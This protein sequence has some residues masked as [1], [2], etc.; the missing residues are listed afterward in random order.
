MKPKQYDEDLFA[1]STMTFGEHLE[2]LRICLWKAILGLAA[3]VIVG[4][5]F[6]GSVVNLIQ[7]PLTSALSKYYQKDA[8]AK[9]AARAGQSGDK[10][11]AD[12]KVDV[13]AKPR[14]MTAEEVCID[15]RELLAKLNAAYP[16]QFEDIQLPEKTDSGSEDQLIHVF[17]WRKWADDP[18]LHLKV[19]NVWEG[20]GIYVK[21]AFL[22]GLVL[23]SPWVFYQ[24]WNFVAAGLYPHEKK[25]VYFYLP[26]SMGLFIFGAC[27]A[28]LFVFEPVLN[29]LFEVNKWLGIDL[30]PR[31]SEWL[32]FALILPVGFG[33]GF[34]LP[35]VMYFLERVGI[36]SAGIFAKHW[37]I[38]VLLIW[39]LATMLTP[40][41]PFSQFFLGIPLTFL[42]FGGILLCKYLPKQKRMMSVEG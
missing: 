25:Y 23:S 31:I 18:R 27:V 38:A 36:V 10:S 16:R 14:G 4:F 39:V 12:K 11:K 28:F 24:I 6:G 20:F 37:K 7:R 30:D 21:A 29:F 9:I 3:G 17:L 15:P 35:L 8:E 22:V 19:F 32:G 33:I 2:E 26:I 1:E 13:M 34:Q 5:I 41:D 40:P 42:Y